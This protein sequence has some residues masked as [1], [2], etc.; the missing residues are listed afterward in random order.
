MLPDK[1][2]IPVYT[3][4]RRWPVWA[5]INLKLTGD[6]GRVLAIAFS[7]KELIKNKTLKAV[8]GNPRQCK[9]IVYGLSGDPIDLSELPEAIH[10]KDPS[11]VLLR[12]CYKKKQ[13]S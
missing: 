6:K 10:L 11:F 8:N 13:C 9:F 1:T 7:E 5:W 2:I 12:S 4:N 3:L